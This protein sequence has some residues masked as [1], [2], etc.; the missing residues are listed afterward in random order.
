MSYIRKIGNL[1]YAYM[2]HRV[3]KSVKTEYLGTASGVE[4]AAKLI[5]RRSKQSKAVDYSRDATVTLPANE[6]NVK[7]WKA[8]KSSIDLRGLDT[9][10]IKANFKELLSKLRSVSS[11]KKE[12]ESKLQ[13]YRLK[14]EEGKKKPE[15]YDQA[16]ITGVERKAI[17]DMIKLYGLEPD[18]VDVTALWDTTLN[19]GENK[20]QIEQY[21]Q[22][23]SKGKELSA[24]EQEIIEQLE[25]HLSEL[26]DRLI[27]AQDSEQKQELSEQISGYSEQLE[28]YKRG[29]FE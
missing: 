9:G 22:T 5:D 14:I 20:S 23:H 18:S 24:T 27:N 15:R 10:T 25:G 19:Y 6:K 29:E 3:G 4:E 28:R 7:L 8:N 17:Y 16:N 11:Q 21:L 1:Y 13:T 2:S 26:H 12:I